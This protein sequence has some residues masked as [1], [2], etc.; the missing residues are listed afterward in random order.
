[1]TDGPVITG[2]A[3][4]VTTAVAV[5][6]EEMYEIVVVPDK[7]PD[8]TPLVLT[9]PTAGVEL[10]QTPPDVVSKSGVADPTHV[11]RIPVIGPTALTVTD[12]KMQV[13]ASRRILFI[14]ERVCMQE[15]F[16]LMLTY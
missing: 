12:K 11:V 10:T 7:M 1:M 6:V 13:I 16:Y 3:V 9:V 14:I 2:A 15:K 8:T 5:P 4:T